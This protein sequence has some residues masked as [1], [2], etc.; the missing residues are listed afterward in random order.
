MTTSPSVLF[1]C[2][3]NGGKSQMAAALAA[4]HAG[5][6]LE[7]HSAGTKPGAKLNAQ[8]VEAIAEVGADMS[9]GTPKGI[10]PELLRRVDRTVILGAD[11]E[12][13]L[14]EDA[15]GTLE[16]WVTDEPSERGIEGVER[17][18]LVRDDIDARVQQLVAE[19]AG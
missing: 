14:P 18:R 4:K 1:V 8:S 7:I 9:Q 13:E 10:D 16:R 6:R 5:D 17:M 3:G 15:R 11:A 2:V 19:L 12:L